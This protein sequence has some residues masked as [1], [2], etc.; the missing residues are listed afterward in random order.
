MKANII[1]PAVSEQPDPP[2]IM[3]IFVLRRV[4]SKL[5][6]MYQLGNVRHLAV[7]KKIR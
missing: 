3:N 1:T 2:H 5:I 6:T 7:V 4:E